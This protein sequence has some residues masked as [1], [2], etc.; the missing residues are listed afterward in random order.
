MKKRRNLIFCIA[1]MFVVIFT[2]PLVGQDPDPIEI[3]GDR[4]KCK[5]TTLGRCKASGSGA[6]CA[7]SEPG[8][9]INCSDYD[10]N[11]GL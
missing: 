2:F 3:G 5:C 9:N 10:G 1:F 11:C 4:I 6:V 7:Q 8:G